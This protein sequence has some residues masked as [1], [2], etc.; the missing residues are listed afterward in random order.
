MPRSADVTD[1]VRLAPSFAQTVRSELS[2]FGQVI[3]SVASDSSVPASTRKKLET[4]SWHFRSIAQGAKQ[5]L[6][7][8]D[9]DY[10]VT[11]NARE[12]I[13]GLESLLQR[14]LGGHVLQ[15]HVAEDLWPI[16]A[17]S[18]SQFEEILL[19]LMTNSRNAM[20]ETGTVLLRAR[21]VVGVSSTKAG[22]DASSA[23]FVSI[24]VIDTGFG[25]SRDMI[26]RIFEP[27]ISVDGSSGSLSL[28]SINFAVKGLGGWVS[29]DSE[30]GKGTAFHEFSSLE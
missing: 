6:Q 1:L 10:L 21:N 14:I 29:I 17:I 13:L 7:I 15:I 3:Q 23:E 19:Y 8:T 20:R 4:L 22:D 30:V 12:R 2:F 27:F 5:F 28:A 26:P 9:S 24:E 11:V 16:Q 18:D 25:V